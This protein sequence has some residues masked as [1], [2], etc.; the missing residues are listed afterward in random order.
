VPPNRLTASSVGTRPTIRRQSTHSPKSGTS[1][2]LTLSPPIPL[3]KSGEEARDVERLLHPDLSPLGSPDIAS[4]ASFSDSA[5]DLPASIHRQPSDGS[6]DGKAAPNP[7]QPSFSRLED[8]R[9]LHS[10]QDLPI[11]TRDLHEASHF[12]RKPLRSSQEVLQET[13]SFLQ[14]FT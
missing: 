14:R 9:R 10:L 11:N 2:S 8:F 3:L 7:S 4:F 1:P 13:S 6:D 5:G 12:H